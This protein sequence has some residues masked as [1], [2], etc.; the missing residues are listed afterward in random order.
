LLACHYEELDPYGFLVG[1]LAFLLALLF[2]Y[3]LLQKFNLNRKPI[4]IAFI[5][6]AIGH[7]IGSW[8][9]FEFAVRVGADSCFYFDNAATHTEAITGYQFAFRTLGYARKYFL[10]ESFLG[11]F[12]I[13]GAIA[14][15]ASTYLVITYKVLLDKISSYQPF[16]HIDKK[17]II[18]P[19]IILFCWPSYFFW[20]AGIVKDNFSFLG[21]AISLFTIVQGRFNFI[22]ITIGATAF[23]LAFMVRPYLLVIFAVPAFIY[24]VMGSKIKIHYKLTLFSFLFVIF[25]IA[26]PLLSQYS[27]ATHFDS[28]TSLG[29][30]AIKQQNYMAIG[31]SIPIPTNNPHLIFFFIPY[32]VLGNLLFPLFIGARNLIGIVGSIENFYLLGWLIWFF[33]N[34]S[35]WKDLSSQ[36]RIVKFLMLYFLFGITCLSMISTNLG[37]AMREKIMY[38]PALLLCIFSTYAYRRHI[39]LTEQYNKLKS[40]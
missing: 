22:N 23:T 4:C 25:A 6:S 11:A 24:I 26:F 18:F 1:I 20:S 28:I 34:Y 13:S 40:S 5:I 17:Q 21:I 29:Q 16:Y 10:G 12:L 7:F 27:S 39:V 33:K 30:Y 9:L 19:I 32:L 35:T 15:I 14:L 3:Y 36:L 38:V 37:L 8:V 2:G 31:S